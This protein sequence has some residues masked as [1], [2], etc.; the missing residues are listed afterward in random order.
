MAYQPLFSKNIII[1]EKNL[2]PFT[3][4]IPDDCDIIRILPT[5]DS[6][7]HITTNPEKIPENGIKILRDKVEYF[8]V[9]RNDNDKIF[10]IIIEKAVHTYGIDRRIN[11]TCM[12][13]ISF[14]RMK[15]LL[16]FNFE[17]ILTGIPEGSVVY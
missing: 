1:N 9:M 10:H 13:D 16:E 6:I 14:T 11:I 5:I 12:K 3:L 7:I 8:N 17:A 4:E 15:G 2:G